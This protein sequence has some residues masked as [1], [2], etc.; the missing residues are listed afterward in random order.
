MRAAGL[1]APSRYTSHVLPMLTCAGGSVSEVPELRA[2]GKLL[3]VVEA[4]LRSK[5]AGAAKMFSRVQAARSVRC[6]SCGRAAS[7]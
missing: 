3:S 5:F 4:W 7:C 6:R 2:G 1:Q